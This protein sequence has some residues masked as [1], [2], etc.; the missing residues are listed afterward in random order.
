MKPKLSSAEQTRLVEL[1]QYLNL[2]EMRRFADD[3]EL[4]LYIHVE[5]SDGSLKRTTDRDRKDIV[6]SRFLNF[7]LN[8]VRTGPTIY[9]HAIVAQGPL[10]SELTNRTRLRYNQYEKHNP[11]FL[12]A[13]A[14]LTNGT[15]R[16][17]MIARLVLR[18]FWTAGKAPTLRQFADEWSRAQKAHTSPRP[19]GAYLVDRWKGEAGPDWKKTRARN[20]REAL[21]LVAKTRKA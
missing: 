20:A 17:G 15:F 19:E 21:K 14:Q 11:R 9:A 3:H 13:M 10:P 16:T 6:L 12:N 5:R 4:E 18:D 2:E 1:I 7:A 8:G